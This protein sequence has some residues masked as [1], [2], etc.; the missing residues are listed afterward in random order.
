MNDIILLENNEAIIESETSNVL[1]DLDK[2]I[3][4]LTD[5]RESIRSQIKNEMEDKGIKKAINK[6]GTYSIT[7][8][9]EDKF[10]EKFDTTKFRK[11]NPDLYD[12]YIVL[13]TK[14]SFITCRMRE[15]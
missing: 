13:R 3:K 9:P 6:T 1:I 12:K 8:T 4:D 5:L 2:K 7:F 14:S 15:E 10:V 11:E